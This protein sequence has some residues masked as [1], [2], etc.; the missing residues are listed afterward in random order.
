MT[1]KGFRRRGRLSR[2]SGVWLEDAFEE[3]LTLIEEGFPEEALEVLESIPRRGRRMP[4]FWSIRAAAHAA[5]GLHYHAIADLEEALRRDPADPMARA[6]LLEACITV[7]LGLHVARTLRT[8]LREAPALLEDPDR[9]REALEEFD[10]LTAETAAPYGVDPKDMEQAIWHNERAELE[11]NLGHYTKAIGQ[12][13]RAIHLV[14]QWPVPRNNRAVAFFL[15]GIPC[16]AIAEEE[17]VVQDLDPNNAMALANL[18]QFHVCLGE[19]AQAQAYASR[20][21]A[22]EPEPG[23][24]LHRCIEALAYLEEDET[25]WHLAQRVLKD[26]ELR[27]SLLPE[28][29]YWLGTAAAN[30]GQ[31]REARRLFKHALKDISRPE[32]VE[33]ALEGLKQKRGPALNGR[34]PY[35]LL[36]PVSPSV[37]ETLTRIEEDAQQ[38]RISAASCRK[39]LD[40]LLASCPQLV[41]MAEKVLWDEGRVEEALGM[42]DFLGTPEAY[43][44]IERFAT[45][46]Y[47]SNRDRLLAAKYLLEAGVWS[48]SETYRFW[49]AEGQEWRDVKLEAEY[50]QE[51][52]LPPEVARLLDQADQAFRSRDWAQ[53]ESLL[54]Q[55][56]EIAPENHVIAHN[57]ALMC[58]EQE[59]SEEAERWLRRALE[60]RPRYALSRAV[61]ASHLVLTGRPVE[62]RHHLEILEETGAMR[63]SE[64]AMVSYLMAHIHL[65]V[66]EFSPREARSYL[67][68]L[69]RIAPDL[70]DL[71]DLRGMVEETPAVAPTIRRLFEAGRR[72]HRRLLE[73]PLQ[74]E[75]TL[76]QCLD[77]LS[78]ETLAGTARAWAVS[79]SGRKAQL[80]DRLVRTITD[81]SRLAQLWEELSEEERDALHWI[82][83][84]DGVAAWTAF[85]DRWGSDLDESPYWQWHKPRMVLG[86]LKMLGLVTVGT[87]EG[88]RVVFVPPELRSLLKRA[89]SRG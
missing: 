80:I 11:L 53:A 58:I 22:W 37:L 45:S 35:L 36:L 81:E 23:P 30:T 17:K 57:L 3:A 68:Q 41:L 88:A 40:Q 13:N 44:A 55:A 24:A 7:G 38:G 47:G 78:R 1:S 66:A 72:Y 34:F 63:D 29:L 43:A 62:A 26:R 33:R 46:Q 71:Q 8:L 67:R 9:T 48:Q 32:V 69:E 79:A 76:S 27:E 25:L 85:V 6:L 87:L 77:R 10:R 75:T 84:R 51:E 19:R 56:V 14:P 4:V 54:R 64:G 83:Q 12:A 42:L 82:M 39:R 21:R 18:I 89:L 49:D 5:A 65:A 28:P 59:K 61:L 73:K 70:S 86:R 2:R 20:L 60:I 52:A 50:A 74:A 16:R 15:S 31:F